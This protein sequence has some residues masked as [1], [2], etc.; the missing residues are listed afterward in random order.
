MSDELDDLLKRGGRVY[1]AMQGE[2]ESESESEEPG[3]PPGFAERVQNNRAVGKS[4]AL[5]VWERAC[6]AG[7]ACALAIAMVTFWQVEEPER[8]LAADPW[9]DMPMISDEPGGEG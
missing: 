7:T 3:L 9:M 6:Y 2:S 1:R 5:A 8:P 4:P